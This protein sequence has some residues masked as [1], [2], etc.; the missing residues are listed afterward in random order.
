MVPYVDGPKMGWT[1]DDA[2][3]SRFLRW[4]IKCENILDWEL[5]ILQESAKCK[6]VVQWSGDAGLD[7]YIPWALPTEEV[8]LQTILSRFEDFCKPQ[9]NAV[10]ARFDLLMTFQQGNRSIDEWY[11]VVQVHIPLCE[12]PQE[13]VAIITRDIFWFFMTDNEFIAKIIN[14]GNTDLTQYPAAK[15]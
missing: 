12:Y 3:H 1:V 4:K 6:K 2:L 11:N 9:S 13:T 7:I 8:I 15:V 10:H 14:E 5:A